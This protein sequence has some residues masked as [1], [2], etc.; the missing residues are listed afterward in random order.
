MTGAGGGVRSA[1]APVGKRILAWDTGDREW[2][3]AGFDA[4]AE[5]P[6]W[7]HVPGGWE[8]EFT[9]WIELPPPI[10]NAEAGKR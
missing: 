7:R 8:V 1:S 4:D 6:S 10:A 5:T 3:I 2:V 9:Y